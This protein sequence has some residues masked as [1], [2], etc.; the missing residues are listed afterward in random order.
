MLPEQKAEWL[1]SYDIWKVEP[2]GGW[3]SMADFDTD[4]RPVEF[5]M[6]DGKRERH[7]AMSNLLRLMDRFEPVAWRQPDPPP[8]KDSADFNVLLGG[9]I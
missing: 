8:N 1:A 2:P 5:L 6:Q 4:A 9:I 7:P 3:R